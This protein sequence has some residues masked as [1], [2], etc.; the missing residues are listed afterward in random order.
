MQGICMWYRNHERGNDDASD[1]QK[2]E[3]PE[4]IMDA[5]ASTFAGGH[6]KSDQRHKKVEE[7]HWKWYFIHG[8]VAS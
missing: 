5:S 8:H 7:C 3:E 1:K 4:P 2:F 6:T